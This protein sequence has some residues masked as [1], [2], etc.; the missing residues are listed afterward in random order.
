MRTNFGGIQWWKCLRGW[1]WL[2]ARASCFAVMLL[3][4]CLFPCSLVLCKSANDNNYNHLNFNRNIY[5][6]ST[7]TGGSRAA[8]EDSSVI[9]S[10]RFRDF[11]PRTLSEYT[12]P[13]TERSP[14]EA[15][16]GKVMNNE[17]NFSKLKEDAS[18]KRRARGIHF[19]ADGKDLSINLEFIVPLL[20]LPVSRSLQLTQ[21]A[22]RKLADLNSGTL[23]LGG[24]IAVVGAFIA[25]VLKTVT[26]PTFYGYGYKKATRA[27]DFMDT[28]NFVNHAP[29]DD[30]GV[31]TKTTSKAQEVLNVLERN[32][33]ANNI[34]ISACA[35]RAICNYVQRSTAGVHGGRGSPTERIVD[36]L[37]NL[38]LLKAYLNGTALKNAIDLGRTKD[39]ATCEAIYR[40][41]RWSKMQNTAWKIAT[42][43]FNQLL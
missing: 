18:E 10:F 34:N 2:S 37:V 5:D 25:A 11:E 38:D 29:L 14:A 35:Q 13:A 28:F 24:G 21:S 20:R 6:N 36:G 40:N 43:V 30:E 12:W 1:L 17:E 32:L 23:L 22:F 4:L 16:E 41:C 7:V 42:D 39:A 26:T 33:H 3:F 8:S 31:T 15:S 9:H 27:A 19:E